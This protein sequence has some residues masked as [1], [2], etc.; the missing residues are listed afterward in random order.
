MLQQILHWRGS[1]EPR[2][3]VVM[4]LPNVAFAAAGTAAVYYARISVENCSANAI[5][6]NSDQINLFELAAVV[7]CP[8]VR[9]VK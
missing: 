7:Y 5:T 3:A 9:L 4:V 2:L 6:H 8:A 1:A